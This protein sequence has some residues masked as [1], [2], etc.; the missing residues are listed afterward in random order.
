[1]KLSTL[2]EAD[3]S[4]VTD[5]MPERRATYFNKAVEDLRKYKEE[6]ELTATEF[7]EMKEN[8]SYGLRDAWGKL[9]MQPFIYQGRYESLP[10][11][12]NEIIGNLNIQL[13][14]IP[15]TLKKAK[16]APNH[17]AT[18]VAI[19]FLESLVDIS[20]D[21]KSLKD[22]IVK[23]KKAIVNAENKKTEETRVM[24]GDDDVQRVRSA[25]EQ[26][27][28]DLK[29][30]LYNNNLSWLTRI[31]NKW[32][33]QYD[34]ANEKT[35]PYDF[36]RNSNPFAYMILQR[37]TKRV[38]DYRDEKH[39]LNDDYK[40]TLAKE[41][42]TISED[43]MNKFVYKNTSKL[44]QILVKKGGLKRVTLKGASTDSGTVEGTL[45][46]EFK[47]KSSFI[48]TSGLVWSYSKNGTSF[49]RYPTTFHR[50]VFPD[51]TKMHGRASEER[52][53]TEFADY[54]VSK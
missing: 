34:P 30:D 11:K 26:I 6:G 27:T 3:T 48:V 43:M 21:I 12:V 37:T 19:K 1:M 33:E 16:T 23:K 44:A 24:M 49:A 39:V 13:H 40:A 54:G 9:V 8:L 14:T 38:G 2:K 52:M 47:D 31:V 42:K 46:L 25:L 15:G 35:H 36:Y 20:N 4:F 17:E 5:A 53:K 29:D 41:A 28:Q 10:T 45:F 18:R 7:K 50:V 22:K 32:A 51:G